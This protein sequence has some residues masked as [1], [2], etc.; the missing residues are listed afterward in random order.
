[1]HN[2]HRPALV[3]LLGHRQWLG[4]L[5]HDALLRLDAQVQLKLPIDPIDPLVIPAEAFVVAQEQEEEVEPPAPVR[6]RQTDKPV[7]DL[8]ILVGALRLIPVAGFADSKRLTGQPDAEIPLLYSHS[9][10]LESARRPH[11][12]FASAS[13]T[14]SALRRSS[15]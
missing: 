15:A 13:C 4:A 2:G 10:D 7:E 8:R 11:D 14:I 6:L 9:D 1:M 3:D 5:G 12:I